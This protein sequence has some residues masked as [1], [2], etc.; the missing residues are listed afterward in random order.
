MQSIHCL[1]VLNTVA[2]LL[3]S[4]G[5]EDEAVND[6]VVLGVC[7]SCFIGKGGLNYFAEPQLVQSVKEKCC[8]LSSGIV[9]QRSYV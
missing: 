3:F 8:P 9:S 6:M 5:E 1:F 2:T 7:I 4:A